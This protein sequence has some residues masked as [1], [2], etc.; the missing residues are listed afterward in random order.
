MVKIKNLLRNIFGWLGYAIVPKIDSQKFLPPELND[1]DLKIIKYVLH[2][3]LSMV[4][5]E[6]LI[7]TALS[8]RYVIENN[9]EGD[10]V[11]CGVWRG[12][13]SLIAKSIFAETSSSKHVYLFDTFEGMTDPTS[14]DVE[15]VSGRSALTR[16]RSEQKSMKQ[17]NVWAYASLEMVKKVFLNKKLLDESV[18][19]VQGKVE[20]TLNDPRNLP[21]KIS[22]LRLDTDWYE[23]TKMELE[24]LY[25]RLSIGGVLIVDDYGHWQGST[26]AVDEYF[27]FHGFRPLLQLTDYSGRAGIK[28][29]SHSK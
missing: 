10:F 22:V 20:D 4:S 24:V 18:H 5:A 23:S 1:Q 7:V 14:A 29:F 15:K 13:N 8:C 16:L 9:I 6:R 19:F 2:E 25:P 3:K 11:E 26:K 27:E 21:D 17:S 28:V 12:G